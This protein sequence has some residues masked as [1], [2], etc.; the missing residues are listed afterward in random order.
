MDMTSFSASGA[1]VTMTVSSEL[2]CFSVP[3][4]VN[5]IKSA[6]LRSVNVG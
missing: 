6:G 4:A 3:D 5:D 1:P 2:S